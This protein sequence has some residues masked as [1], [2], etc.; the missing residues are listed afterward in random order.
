ML[1]L[2]VICMCVSVADDGHSED[3]Q[4]AITGH[5]DKVQNAISMI[6]ELLANANVMDVSFR[7]FFSCILY[8]SLG[9][10]NLVITSYFYICMHIHLLTQE[11]CFVVNIVCVS[12][13]NIHQTS[14][15]G[16]L[17]DSCLPGMLIFCYFLLFFFFLLYFWPNPKNTCM[18]IFSIFSYFIFLNFLF[19]FCVHFLWDGTHT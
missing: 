13:K 7:V 17:K 4:C 12:V 11:N 18:L 6:H 3:R 8:C 2:Y 15:T 5:P 1:L 9:I 19:S 14:S 10:N 16:K